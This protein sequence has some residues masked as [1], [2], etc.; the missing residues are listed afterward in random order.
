MTKQIVKATVLY[1][2]NTLLSRHWELEYLKHKISKPKTCQT[3]NAPNTRNKN[4]SAIYLN[5]K[6]KYS[7]FGKADHMQ[8]DSMMPSCYHTLHILC[9]P[10][11]VAN[12]ASVCVF[13][14]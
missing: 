1:I 2:L 10:D 7:E 14:M 4:L 9:L 13:E 6:T 5:M 11:V 8:M 3:S 12:G